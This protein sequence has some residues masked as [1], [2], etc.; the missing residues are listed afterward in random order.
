M[1]HFVHFNKIKIKIRML[2]FN[3]FMYFVA[4][5]FKQINICRIFS[6]IQLRL[7]YILCTLSEDL[8]KMCRISIL[9]IGIHSLLFYLMMQSMYLFVAKNL[10]IYK[11]PPTNYI[12]FP[13]GSHVASQLVSQA[14]YYITDHQLCTDPF[15]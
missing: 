12:N 9:Y 4:I 1:L 7:C 11:I 8:A 3:K 15:N 2:Q 5:H 10:S 6:T 13:K 14:H